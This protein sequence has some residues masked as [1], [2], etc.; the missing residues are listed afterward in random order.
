MSVSVP[1][2]GKADMSGT[3]DFPAHAAEISPNGICE[4]DL[5][6]AIFKT[7]T[8]RV[9]QHFFIRLREVDALNFVWAKFRCGAFGELS[10]QPGLIDAA[11]SNRG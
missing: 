6:G 11:A 5:D 9:G 7:D 3:G 8:H 10:A 2:P 4:R 1:F